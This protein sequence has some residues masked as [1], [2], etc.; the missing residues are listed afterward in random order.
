MRSPALAAGF[1]LLAAT[2]SSCSLIY[3]GIRAKTVVDKL[4]SGT[5]N[6]APPPFV[7]IENE[8]TTLVRRLLPDAY[9][10]SERVAG[11]VTA[12]AVPDRLVSTVSCVTSAV[13]RSVED[14]CFFQ[15]EMDLNLPLAPSLDGLTEQAWAQEEDA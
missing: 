14:A 4:Q 10:S 9:W 7:S 15:M 1:I 2:S 5:P 6:P 13:T 8:V 11:W 3:N 12:P